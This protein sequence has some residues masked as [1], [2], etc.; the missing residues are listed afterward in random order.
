VR[1]QEQASLS[2]GSAA[3]DLPLLQTFKTCVIAVRLSQGCTKPTLS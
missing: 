2:G 3:P 1:T